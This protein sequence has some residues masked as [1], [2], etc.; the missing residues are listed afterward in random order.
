M[1]TEKIIQ[2]I[3][4]FVKAQIEKDGA[5]SQFHVDLSNEKGQQLAKVLNANKNIVLLG[6]L[7]KDCMIGEAIKQGKIGVHV[8]M[9]EAKAKNLLS[10][11]PE[12]TEDETSNILA[13]VR[14]HHGTEKFTS[15]ESEI[16]CNADCYMFSSVRGVL[17]GMIFG[18]RMEIAEYV[19]LY[20]MKA[21]EKWN[22]LTIDICK[23]ELKEQYLAIKKF[24]EEFK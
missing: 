16:C 15:L 18:N 11:F 12:L 5:P 21:D 10:T 22:T 1:I 3:S 24:F 6:T 20:S 7:L 23:K 14:E 13:C 4:N 19:K 17:G 8:K 2:S 9:G